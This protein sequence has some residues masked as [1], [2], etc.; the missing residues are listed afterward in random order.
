M[1]ALKNL[2]TEHSHVTLNFCQYDQKPL[3]SINTVIPAAVES[4]HR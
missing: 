1:G 3:F 4:Q 2:K